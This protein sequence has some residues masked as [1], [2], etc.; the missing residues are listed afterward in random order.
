[1]YKELFERINNNTV[2]LTA[3]RRLAL[4]LQE[5]YARVQSEAGKSV[6]PTSKILPLDEWLIQCWDE[7]TSKNV[8]PSRV[9][10][11]PHQELFIWDRIVAESS[12]GQRTL[13][14]R[15]TA[16]Q[17]KQTWQLCTQWQVDIN[18]FTQS[19]DTLAFQSWAKDFS[20]ECRKN[21]YIDSASIINE[22]TQHINPE[23]IPSKENIRSL[24]RFF[25]MY[26]S[27]FSL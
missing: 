2:V 23:S 8:L 26:S 13:Y 6:W 17:A 12:L 18:D 7:L 20:E 15:E 1:M 5:Q 19:E 14:T 4:S 11:N 9:I 10:L 22:I 3:N 21:N 25:S 24:Y 16:K 27:Y